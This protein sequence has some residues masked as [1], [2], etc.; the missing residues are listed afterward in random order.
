MDELTT[1][2][3]SLEKAKEEKESKIE[4]EK[5]KSWGIEIDGISYPNKRNAIVQ[6]LKSGMRPIE[7]LKKINENANKKV[8]NIYVYKLSSEI[9]KGLWNG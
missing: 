8:S 1:I 2:Q 6:M 3:K 5:K 9:K 7:C 4:E